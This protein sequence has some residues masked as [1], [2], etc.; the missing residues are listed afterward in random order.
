[1]S[2]VADAKPATNGA[3]RKWILA[4]TLLALVVAYAI[5]FE[6]P[7]MIQGVFKSALARIADLGIWAPVL[8][9]LL[10]IVACVAL[11]PGAFLTLG[12]GAI[13]GVVKGSFCVSIGAT[14]GATAAFLVGRHFARD[15]VTR[16]IGRNP[17]FAAID[18]AVAEEGWKIVLLTRLSPVFPFFLLNYAYGLTRVSLRHYVLATWIGILPGSTLFVYIGSL[19]NPSEGKNSPAAWAFKIIGLLATV[20]VTVYITKVA[21]RALAK[22]LP[23]QTAASTGEG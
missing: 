19:A 1:M 9:V 6:L 2:P 22:K 7:G 11:I 3:K 15:W 23:A 17:G 4:L 21:R 13:F 18:K 8:F 20:L 14:L 10:Y 5:Y 16:K 12:A